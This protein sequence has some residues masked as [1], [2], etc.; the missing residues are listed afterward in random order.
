MGYTPLILL[1]MCSR[2][3]QKP[4]KPLLCLYSFFLALVLHSSGSTPV[5]CDITPFVNFSSSSSFSQIGF[6][7]FNVLIILIHWV[8]LRDF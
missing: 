1:T 8:I 5:S 3:Q 4:E 6:Y 2:Y 7:Y